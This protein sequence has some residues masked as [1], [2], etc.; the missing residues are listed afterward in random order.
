MSS[1]DGDAPHRPPIDT[2]ALRNERDGNDR[3]NLD[4]KIDAS[5]DLVLSGQDLGPKV[6][7]FFH[8][9]EYEYS[10][11][12]PA[13]YKD[14]MLLRLLAEKFEAEFSLDDWLQSHAIPYE[15]S[16]WYTPD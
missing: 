12:I 16:N 14:S 3:R 13:H 10:Y 1:K 11:T 7:E 8:T 6:R 9:D 2:V 4:A 5:G 15:F